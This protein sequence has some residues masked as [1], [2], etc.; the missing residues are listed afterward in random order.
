MPYCVACVVHRESLG[1]LCFNIKEQ[2]QMSF[3]LFF[4]MDEKRGVRK[5][6]KGHCNGAGISSGFMQQQSVLLHA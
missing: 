5:T 3:C 2:L 1:C 4:T 6:L